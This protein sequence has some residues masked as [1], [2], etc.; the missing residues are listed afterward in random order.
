MTPTLI[1]DCSIAMAWCFEDEATDETKK[2]QERM[3]VEAAVVP[4][5]WFQEVANVLAMAEKRGRI[6]VAD[7]T[8]L[9]QLLAAL[10]IQPDTE[11]AVRAFEHILPLARN[12]GLTAYDAA[13]LELAQR[14]GLPLASLDDDLRAAGARLGIEMLGK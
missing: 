6:S 13:Y 3:I 1:I 11:S 5:I 10:E 8:Q 4:T 7:S 2:I 9:V 14:K 12:H